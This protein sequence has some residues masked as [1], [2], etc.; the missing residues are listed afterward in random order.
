[1]I[2]WTHKGPRSKMRV[3][4]LTMN[5]HEYTPIAVVCGQ[6]VIKRKDVEHNERYVCL[7][8]RG[9]DLYIVPF[10]PTRR[11]H[12]TDLPVVNFYAD[13]VDIALS[14]EGSRLTNFTEYLEDALSDVAAE[15]LYAIRANRSQR[16]SIRAAI[17]DLN[18]VFASEVAESKGES[19]AIA[20]APT[21]PTPK[22]EPE[23][24]PEPAIESDHIKLTI[25]SG[26]EPKHSDSKVPMNWTPLSLADNRIP[27]VT[28][29]YATHFVITAR[30][31][32]VMN[33]VISHVSRWLHAKFP[34]ARTIDAALVGALREP[35]ELDQNATLACRRHD[36]ENET[37]WALELNEPDHG[38]RFRT[39]HTQMGMRVVDDTC[40][41]S[42]LVSYS[43]RPGAY[44]SADPPRPT[45]PRVIYDIAT[46]AELNATWQGMPV[47]D[48][49]DCEI[50]DPS[51]VELIIMPALRDAHHAPLIVAP[52]DDDLLR[53]LGRTTIGMAHLCAFDDSDDWR[54]AL[55]YSFPHGTDIWRHRPDP[56]RITV[57]SGGYNAYSFDPHRSR[58]R[59]LRE[60]V[61]G[62]VL[63]AHLPADTPAQIADVERVEAADARA[64][65]KQR[66][67]ELKEQASAETK[68]KAPTPEAET[69]PTPTTDDDLWEF[70]QDLQT[71]LDRT[72]AENHRLTEALS[73]AQH[74]LQAT[75]VD[76][77]VEARLEAVAEVLGKTPVESMTDTLALAEQLWPNHVCIHEDAWRS[78]KGYDADPA[79][80]WR[81][82]RTVATALWDAWFSQT[83]SAPEDYIA[84]R[85]GVEF[86]ACEST[87]TRDHP[88]FMRL[89]DHVIDGMTV[90]VEG[91][92]KAPTRN[93]CT[94]RVYVHKDARNKR[95][96]IVYAGE[97]MRTAGTRRKR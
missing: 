51:D 52:N 82:I 89:R 61:D 23:P 24:A 30:H 69:E 34:Q 62:L 14:Q 37:I 43:P 90:R 22:P 4:G 94:P 85:A 3:P 83:G 17:D 55:D 42:L 8:S 70:A 50:L 9:Q 41:L 26:P 64:H 56:S 91:H 88:E 40:H 13:I 72:N 95:C 71:D 63:C 84:N 12:M 6:W 78:A 57:Y 97:H 54:A 38:F 1:M 80:C 36:R 66:L 96:V 39:W 20:P 15:H 73:A 81:L 68:T 53:D 60:L 92:L 27:C 47:T 44:G 7:I 87:E 11:R 59:L 31:A 93:G 32:N 74:A 29:Q 65:L 16:R 33:R 75:N 46:D 25:I 35:I 19:N 49:V 58:T 48:K 79:D 45:I 10:T 21:A 86:A 2:V 76:D 77:A 18:A 28:P 67:H 5:G